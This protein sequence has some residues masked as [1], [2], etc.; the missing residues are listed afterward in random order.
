VPHDTTAHL[1]AY[2]FIT[3][4][5]MVPHGVASY[6]AALLEIAAT[7]GKPMA[8]SVARGL[9]Y[10]AQ[11]LDLAGGIPLGLAMLPRIALLGAL[12]LLARLAIGRWMSK[13]R[14][15]PQQRVLVAA[16]DYRF[17]TTTRR[18]AFAAAVRTSTLQNPALRS[19]R[20]ISSRE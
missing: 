12:G 14:S 19:K 15:S 9:N 20:A 2:D 13:R 6:D 5:T 3:F 11:N 10:P 16:S 18:F 17:A 7:H 4:A 1:G 8:R